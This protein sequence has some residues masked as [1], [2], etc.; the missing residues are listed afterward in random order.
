VKVKCLIPTFQGR[1]H[2]TP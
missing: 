1:S 2:A